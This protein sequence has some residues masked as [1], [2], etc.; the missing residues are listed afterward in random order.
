MTLGPQ[1]ISALGAQGESHSAAACKK[2]HAGEKKG[3][4]EKDDEEGE[5][6]HQ[7]TLATQFLADVIS[8]SDRMCGDGLPPLL[9]SRRGVA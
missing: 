6:M 3:G 5:E 9:K 1:P 7:K 8:G 4:S 2:S